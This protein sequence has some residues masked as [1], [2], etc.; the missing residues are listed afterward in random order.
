MCGQWI[1]GY[2]QDFWLGCPALLVPSHVG[3]G[4]EGDTKGPPRRVVGRESPT[5]CPA[6]DT[7]AGSGA[8]AWLSWVISSSWRLCSSQSPLSASSGCFPSLAV[9]CRCPGCG[10]TLSQGVPGGPGVAL[11]RSLLPAQPRLPRGSWASALLSGPVS[12]RT[13][14]E[15]PDRPCRVAE[16]GPCSVP[17]TAHGSLRAGLM[18]IELWFF[19]V[20][21]GVLSWGCCFCL[22][23]RG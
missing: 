17:S 18:Q 3:L 11:L 21:P 13:L 7:L 8:A 16:G 10:R 23:P 15:Q 19:L 5:S 14:G 4:K 6:L 1:S 20:E 22:L 12:G 9:L 2:R